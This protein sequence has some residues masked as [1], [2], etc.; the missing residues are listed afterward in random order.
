MI[1]EYLTKATSSNIRRQWVNEK[2][3]RSSL[4]KMSW[5]HRWKGSEGINITH[6]EI[7][8]ASLSDCGVILSHRYFI[9][10]F[11]KV[12]T[13]KIDISWFG[14]SHIR[15]LATVS[16]IRQKKWLDCRRG[17][18]EV[19]KKRYTEYV[20]TVIK[21]LKGYRRSLKIRS[22]IF[23]KFPD[24]GSQLS[25]VLV[26]R[27]TNNCNCNDPTPARCFQCSFFFLFHFVRKYLI[28]SVWS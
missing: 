18:V 20:M 5:A 10:L 1:N 15:S 9:N 7:L 26:M 8:L 12:N 3:T 13:S 22:D 28:I 19:S 24:A 17:S 27:L 11:P 2:F 21:E 23:L 14:V 16:W 6:I 25:S 4:G